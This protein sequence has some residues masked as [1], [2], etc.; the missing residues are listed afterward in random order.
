MGVIR[1]YNPETGQWE[2]YGSTEAKDINLIDVGDNFSDKNVEGALREI[3]DKLNETLA[4]LDAQKNTL[5]E[6]SSDIEWLKENGGGGGGTGSGAVAPTITSTFESC[7][8][9]KETEINIPIFFTSPNLGEGTAYL[10]INNVEVASIPGIKQGN[11]IIEV[12]KLTDLRSEISI[13][14]K[15]RVNMLSNQLT[16]VV[17]AGG[18]D[19][20]IDFD[21]TADYYVSDM[22]TMQ[23][24]VQSTT[25]DP[26]KTYLTIDYDSFEIDCKNGFNEYTFPQ[27]GLGI[28]KVTMYV[29]DGTYTTQTYNFNVV[30]VNSNSLYVSSTFQGG[31][32][33]IGNPVAIQYRVSKAS[34]EAFNVELYLNDKLNKTLSCVPGAYYWTLNDLDIGEYTARIEVSGAYD[35]TKIIELQFSVV[36][37][38][39]QPLKITEDGLIYRLSAKGRTNQDSDK[40]NPID[41]SG[42]GVTTTL[43]GFNFYSNGW[44]DGELVCDGEAYVE[45]DMFPYQDNALYGSTIE[46]QYTA[47]DIGF[48]DSRVLD[49]T[50][51]E[52]PYKGIYVDIGEAS[53][54]SLNNTGT[55]HVD[56]DTETTLSFVIDRR[57]KFAKV[58]IDGICSR[59]FTLSD[60]GSGTSAIRE[61]FT[62]AQKIFLNSKKGLSNFGACKIKDVRIYNRVLSDDE[63]VS[64]FVAQISNLREQEK[65]YNFEFNNTTLPVIRMYG[66]MTNMTLETPV[67]MRIKYTSPNEDEFGQSFDLPYCQVNWQGTSSLQ[68]VL[69]NFTARLKDESLA[70][71]EYTP[72]V[73]GVKEDVYCFKCDYMESTHSRN[74]GIAKFVNECL[75]DTKNPK[76]LENPNIRNSINGFPCIMYIND[77]LQGVYNFNLDRYS[78]KSFGY[79]DEN[80]VLVYEISANSDSTAGAFYP[81]T[82]A[83][84]KDRLAYYKSDF[85]CLYPPTRAAGN[86]NMSELIR[87][88]EWVDKSSDEDFKDNINNYF[89]LEYLLRYYLNVLVFGLVDSL[90]KNAKLTS[91]DS[92][93]TWYFQFYDADT[94]IGLNN[95][96]FLLF[97]SDIEMGDE[98]V[99]NT[100][101]SRLWQRVVYLFQD[102]LKA[103]YA[104]MRQDRFTVDNIMKYLYDE[105]IARIPATYYN[106]DMQSKY[107]N[108]G[109]SYLYALHGNSEHQIRKWIRERI[110]YVDTLL[111]YMVT[112]SDYITIRA[113]KMGEV[114]FDVEM[115][116]PMYVSVKF[117]DEAD[118]SGMVTKR[119]GRGET[120]RFSYNIPTETDQEILVYCGKNIKS[121]GNLSNMQPSTMLIANASRL[122]EI[123]V[124]S[125]NLIN[126]DLSECKMLQ[127]IDIS[128]CTALGTGI[129]A[130]PILNVQNCKYL[131]YLDC[132]NTQL[133][134]I[135]TMQSGS[136]LEEIYYPQSIQSIQLTNQA[137]LK[138]I[139]IPYETDENGVVTKY[140]ENLADVEINNCR[141]VD[142]THYPYEEGDYVNLDSIKQVQNFTLITSLDKLTGM[143]F[144]G[145]NKLKNLKLSSMHN[146]SSLGFDDMMLMSDLASLENITV[147][148]CPLID[149]VSFN[150]SSIGNKVEFVEGAVIDLGGVQSIKTIESNASIKGLKTMIIPT[151]TENLKFTAEYGDGINDIRN[152]W[153]AASEH[154]LDGFEGIDLLD[155]ELKYLDMG[156]L[157]NITNGINF[158]IAPTEQHPNMNTYRTGTYFR[159]EGVIDLTE[160]NST[161]VGMLK[162]VDLSKLE[163]IVDKNKDQDDLTGLFEGAIL[164]ES[165]IDKV[166]YILDKFNMSTNWSN[167]FRDS[168]IGF[169]SDEVNIPDENTYRDM[170][171]SGMFCNTDVSKDIKITDNIRNVTDMFKD[172]KNMKEYLNNWEDEHNNLLT[173]NCYSGT[174]GNLELV[175]V[176]WGGYGFYDNVTSEIVVRIPRAGYELT[177]ANRYK[178][179]SYGM[180]NWGDGVIDCLHDNKFSHTFENAGV[181]TI[182]GHFTFG[183]GYVCNTSL[184]SVLLEVKHIAGDTVDLN[185]AFKYCTSLTKVNLNGLKPQILSEMFSGCTGLVDIV[186]D[187]LD[188]TDVTDVNNMF[189][190]CSNLSSLNLNDK[191]FDNLLDMR[192]MFSG[193]IALHD[194][195]IEI[196][197]SKVTNMSGL[198]NGCASL[199]S[200]NLDSFDTEQVTNMSYM[201]SSCGALTGLDLSGFNTVNVTEMQNMF[202]GC[203]AIT[204]INLNGFDTQKVTN[205]SYMF[206]GCADITNLQLNDFVTTGLTNMNSMFKGCSKLVT[207]NM[208]NFV[209]ENVTDMGGL[210]Y[211]C[212]ALGNINLDNFNTI[213][214][215]DMN[216]MF[217]GCTA[218]VELDLS[219][220]DTT[221]V[222]TMEGMFYECSN[223]KSLDLSNFVTTSLVNMKSMFYKCNALS[224]VKVN[225]F[226]TAG[227]SDMSSLFY[228]CISL[229]GVE[230]DNFNTEN[231]TSMSYMFRGCSNIA[232][233]N[234][235]SFDTS[236]VTSMNYMFYGCS[237]LSELDISH[238]VTDKLTNASAMFRGCEGLTELDVTNF[239]TA[240]ITNMSYIF[241]DC[242]GLKTLD[243]SNFNTDKVTNM[244][245]M[246][247]SCSGLSQLSLSNFN[248]ENVTT[249]KNLFYDCSSL[250]ALN[251]S[252]FNTGKVTSM[253]GM[254]NGC[255][256][257]SSL[258]ISGFITNNVTNM[259]GMF[260]NCRNL[261]S[262]DLSLFNTD[263]VTDMSSMFS[264]CSL[265]VSFTNKT[266]NKLTKVNAMFNIFYGSSIDLSDF[267]IKNSTNNENFITVA[268]NLINLK[269]PTNI[270]KHIKITAS[271]LSVD[272]LMSIINNLATVTTT[273]N[274]EIGSANLA[275]LTDEQIAIAVNK[276]WSLS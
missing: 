112:S 95:S 216:N 104:L 183:L 247:N 246:F 17:T 49:Y 71:Y 64:N 215:V 230:L 223:I 28:H 205:M 243:V 162:G 136:N 74:V 121:L 193:C 248:T 157:S 268:P 220:F 192:Y 61:D 182:K 107:L 101:G 251:L 235:K 170:N 58:F 10:I 43:H 73:N 200:V 175:P 168:D 140:C 184:N 7:T 218:I 222:T 41:D 272:S 237:S 134:S 181:Y 29:S 91:F 187:E 117:R 259:S 52:V 88:I 186:M 178:T 93:L 85:E 48:D 164:N 221:G 57:N 60:T 44:I 261:S 22:I 27:L 125:P 72:Y 196:N 94:S 35:E 18:I 165:E 138:T 167:L 156:K 110:M 260:G 201:F 271:S 114:Y 256:A 206:N 257:L 179:T 191:K 152:I 195:N 87:L 229:T 133:T 189:N 126:T 233:L 273:Q 66:D 232:S 160:Y 194:L 47:L 46:I 166:N 1:K 122:T 15:D 176:P 210:F 163:I 39:Y 38:G 211:G 123:E 131:R 263:K 228:D 42:K 244:S 151:S 231:V 239:N 185:Q 255:T 116:Q 214:V 144:K 130:Q 14:V 33:E 3:S 12:G 96:G 55:V 238:F 153:S 143:S 139:G 207:L 174:G 234:L 249:M 59:A 154:T 105:Q 224:T 242:S 75:Y 171:L 82:E 159:P 276:N 245:D 127:R 76:Q 270:S 53:M 4:N 31:E 264:G 120:V 54:K 212:A 103:Q 81:W 102:E 97:E 98:H 155:I 254:F 30:I 90:G 25:Q 79:T 169:D 67:T 161:M 13:Y 16:W 23:Y 83:S 199:S 50:D 45:I 258:N 262:I 70:T 158:N 128:D 9:D 177:L 267:S 11:N 100:T 34:N 68:Y 148:D 40:E 172:C 275:K 265:N 65:K 173:E 32:F 113:N 6:H 92:G 56:R 63:I 69:K 253:Q 137:Y 219:G 202:S 51:I 217:Y 209:T 77:E 135:Y 115:Y 241:Y 227:V 226:N 62:H 86:D 124:H 5:V 141:N 118:N 89:N 188:C 99:F 198:F 252:N 8:I 225:S 119:V 208:A 150:L 129:G 2:V 19:L 24:Y 180:V 111:G 37:S 269:A 80:N 26:I 274:L 132:R 147:S 203:K 204:E 149:T 108:F 236:N 146:I 21:D 36:S 145:F 20:S 213:N 106:K 197:T 266:N 190:S 240:N 250:S 78:T 84:G 109:S 142:Y